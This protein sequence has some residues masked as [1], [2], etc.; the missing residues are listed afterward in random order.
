[1]THKIPPGHDIAVSL[2]N[3]LSKKL[4][5]APSAFVVMPAKKNKVCADC[6]GPDLNMLLASRRFAQK[7]EDY[8][9]NFLFNIK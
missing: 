4:N 7:L 6:H 3:D 2:S 1:M 8:G 9:F 5:P